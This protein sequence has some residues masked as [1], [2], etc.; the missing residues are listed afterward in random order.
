MWTQF[1][2]QENRKDQNIVKRNL[3]FAQPN[4]N[5]RQ[6]YHQYKKLCISSR[7]KDYAHIKHSTEIKEQ[8][9]CHI[10]TRIS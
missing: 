1:G 5:S 6:H 3:E 9:L 7:L 8:V 10:S 4:K 2:L